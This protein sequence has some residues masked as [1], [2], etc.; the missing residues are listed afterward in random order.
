MPSTTPSPPII[1]EN[2]Y[3]IPTALP[4]LQVQVSRY[5]ALLLCCATVAVPFS[6]RSL[7]TSCLVA[8]EKANVQ[9]TILDE[10][11]KVRWPGVMG[12]NGDD[13]KEGSDSGWSLVQALLATSGLIMCSYLVLLG[14]LDPNREETYARLE[15]V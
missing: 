10:H 14:S 5:G 15:E 13:D 3:S 4:K 12:N 11:S 1:N 2:R 6:V 9:D 7:Q 8:A